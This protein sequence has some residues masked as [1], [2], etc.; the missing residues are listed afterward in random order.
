MYERRVSIE[1]IKGILYNVMTASPRTR[2]ATA[3]FAVAVAATTASCVP[4]PYGCTLTRRPGR[5]DESLTHKVRF[6]T[7]M[8]HHVLNH[9]GYMRNPLYKKNSLAAVAGRL[10]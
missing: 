7:K 5:I 2:A 3:V 8:N 10:G 4:G 6:H 1:S 9:Q